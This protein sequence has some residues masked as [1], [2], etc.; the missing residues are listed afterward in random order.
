MNTSGHIHVD[1]IIVGAGIAGASLA[2]ILKNSDI[3]CALVEANLANKDQGTDDQSRT[4]PRALAITI[5]SKNILQS[6]GA[7]DEIPKDRLGCFRKMYVWDE[8]GLGEVNFDSADL[9]ESVMGYIV[10]QR[11]IE[12]ALESAL[13]KSDHISWYRPVEAKTLKTEKDKICM[14]LDDGRQLSASLLVAADG[15]SSTIRRL[16][17]INFKTHD[18]HQHALACVVETELPHQEVACQRFLSRGPLAFLPM[19]KPN[20]CG[21]VWS[22]TPE[23]AVELKNL[24]EKIF[25]KVLAEAFAYHAGEIIHTDSRTTFPLARAQAD[26]YCRPRLALVGDAAHRIHPLAGQ[27][28]NMGLLDVASLAELILQA[29]EK[30]R[31]IGAFSVLRKYE[32]WRKGE[33]STMMMTMEGFKY[34]FENKITG[35]SW[36]RNAGMD[37]FDEIEPIKHEV[38]KRAMGLVGDLP[39]IARSHF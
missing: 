21:I 39:D 31:D 23:Q 6:I 19:A 34:L 16:A 3:T 5:A 13:N 30:G 24:D 17:G 15:Q 32:R 12:Q 9:Y 25:N 11:I 14:G 38:M 27:G 8:N 22:T 1:V 18:Y 2:A 33:N 4:D 35:L 10:E 7:W 28:A 37:V 29:R 26:Q 36:L 20:Q